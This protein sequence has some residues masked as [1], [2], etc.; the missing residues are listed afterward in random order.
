M[1]IP[2]SLRPVLM[3]LAAGCAPLTL[4][5]ALPGQPAPSSK[6]DTDSPRAV[7][8]A[9]D[10]IVQPRFLDDQ[11]GVFG[12]GR[13]VSP[14]RGHFETTYFEPK[15]PAETALWEAANQAKFPYMMGFLHCAHV[16][17]RFTDQQP[18]PDLLSTGFSTSFSAP[19]PFHPAIY[20]LSRLFTKYSVSDTPVSAAV[21]QQRGLQEKEQDKSFQTAALKA[22]P[23]LMK[24]K[25]QETTQGDFLV[26]M[27]PVLAAKDSC[28]GCHIGAKKND[29]LGVMVY[30]VRNTPTNTVSKP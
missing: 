19:D 11:A 12:T 7:A 13:V 18:P 23:A 16:P 4:A 14:V 29:T 17:G 20:S 22:L 15:T 3:A 27:R 8:E 26:V 2:R 30:A 6:T 10:A 1:S 9:L 24:G 5:L 25:T 21:W 28:L